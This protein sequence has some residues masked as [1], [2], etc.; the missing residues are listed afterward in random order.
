MKRLL[1]ISDLHCGHQV[2]LTHP[3]HDLIPTDKKSAEYDLHK[4]RKES[5]TVYRN[6]INKLNPIDV[7]IVNG[8]LIDGEG[9][10]SGGTELLFNDVTKQIDM[11]VAAVNEC[12]AKKI[13]ISYGTPYHVGKSADWENEIASRVNAVEIVSHGW[14]DI[15]GLIIDYRHKVGSS[16]VPYG[17]QSPI[18]KERMWNLLNTEYA[19]FPKSD[20]IIRSHVHY[21]SYCGGSNWLGITTPALQ[22][23]FS[24]YGERQCSGTTDWGMVSFDIESKEDWGWEHH[25]V[26]H[27]VAQIKATVV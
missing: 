17:R 7:L 6:I 26:K 16:S 9:Q 4:I 11:A 15:N 12:E 5:Y 18:A 27:R 8:D 20:V 14:I 19:E 13:F 10:A 23:S 1:V 22:N 2:G 3:N 21:F 25:V 24:K